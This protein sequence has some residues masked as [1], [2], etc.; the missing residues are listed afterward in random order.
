MMVVYKS[1]TVLFIL[2]KTNT[3]IYWMTLVVMYVFYQSN[4]N[5][6]VGSRIS[7]KG[8]HMYKGVCVDGGGGGSLC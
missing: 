2:Q 3:S 4:C 1:N 6:R 8:V 5:D 7:G